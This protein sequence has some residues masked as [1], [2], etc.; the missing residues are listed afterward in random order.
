M[1]RP[2]KM[3]QTVRCLLMFG[4]FVGTIVLFCTV[5][6]LAAETQGFTRSDWDAIMRWVNFIILAVLIIKYARKPLSSFLQNK[7]DEVARLL[8]GYE[9]QNRQR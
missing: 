3:M 5:D 1:K 9:N 8:D 6:A 7:V 4:A 2:L